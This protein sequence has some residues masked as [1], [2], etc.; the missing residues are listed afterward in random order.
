M[1]PRALFSCA[2]IFCC[3]SGDGGDIGF[4]SGDGS[5]STESS[6]QD[7]IESDTKL[8]IEPCNSSITNAIT[9][10]VMGHDISPIG[11]VFVAEA[12]PGD[13]VIVMDEST[14]GCVSSDSERLVLFPCDLRN[15]SFSM[16]QNSDCTATPNGGF[17]LIEEGPDDI[18]MADSGTLVITN[19]NSNCV[20]GS[21]SLMFGTESMAGSFAASYCP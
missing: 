18:A 8:E 6:S 16:L 17:G 20:T 10:T 3:S 21:F 4:D 14:N 7:S 12:S 9:G 2:L 13:F 19:V 1:R 11:S 15:G 5:I